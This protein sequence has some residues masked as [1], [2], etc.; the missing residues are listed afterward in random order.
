MSGQKIGR[1]T[2]LRGHSRFASRARS[3][4]TVHTPVNI[5][6]G[7]LP[8]LRETITTAIAANTSTGP[9][10]R[11]VAATSETRIAPGI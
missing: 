5:A 4:R 2:G 9:P 7:R 8:V 3:A 6:A 10:I 1:R 11:M